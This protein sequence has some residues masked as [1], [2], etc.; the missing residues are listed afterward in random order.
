M[1]E[2]ELA[3]LF[4]RRRQ[5]TDSVRVTI[6][7]PIPELAIGAGGQPPKMLRTVTWRVR[8]GMGNQFIEH[9]KEVVAAYKKA[10][11]PAYGVHRVR[12]GGSRR[13]FVSWTPLDK[14]AELDGPGW[15]SKSMSED[16][17]SKWIEKL[18]PLI[19]HTEWKIWTYQPE[20]SYH[21]EG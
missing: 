4:A 19:E 16:A 20:L 17:R 10:G 14:M 8:P 1:S 5:C 2:A 15:S 7:R 3:A 12:Y 11:I 13:T 9:R 21:P 6:R 18:I